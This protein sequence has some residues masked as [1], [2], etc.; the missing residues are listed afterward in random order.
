MKTNIL[1]VTFLAAIAAIAGYA[2]YA[3]QTKE[4]M[5]DVML[6]NVEAL[7]TGEANVG[8][9]CYKGSYNSSLPEAVK[10]AHPCTKE[11]CGGETRFI[12][13]FYGRRNCVLIIT[14]EL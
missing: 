12:A 8:D 14:I 11:R 10:C 2:V 4:T 9:P 1:K 5:S 7:A 3:S 6:E 13:C